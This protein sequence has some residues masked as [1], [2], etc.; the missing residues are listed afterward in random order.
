MEVDPQEY[1]QFLVWKEQQNMLQKNIETVRAVFEAESRAHTEDFFAPFSADSRFWMN[2]NSPSTGAL[3]GV[4]AMKAVFEAFMSALAS[5]I[6]MTI[7]NVVAAG[8]WVVTET[9]GRAETKD[10]RPYNSHYV[11]LWKFRDSEIVDF[12]EYLDTKLLADTFRF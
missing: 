11:Q 6:S 10:G 5:G 12:R 1:A 9:E 3:Q 2:G 7:T 8:D 4:P